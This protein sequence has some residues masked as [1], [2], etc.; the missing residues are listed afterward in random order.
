MNVH[1]LGNLKPQTTGTDAGAEI[2]RIRFFRHSAQFGNNLCTKRLGTAVIGTIHAQ[3]HH[4]SEMTRH[5]LGVVV[6]DHLRVIPQQIRDGIRFPISRNTDKRC[7]ESVTVIRPEVLQFGFKRCSGLA[8][9]LLGHNVVRVSVFVSLPNQRVE[10]FEQSVV[11]NGR[12]EKTARK[13]FKELCLI[14]LG[15]VFCGN[16]HQSEKLLRKCRSRENAEIGQ[17]HYQRVILAVRALRVIGLCKK[18]CHFQSSAMSS[19]EAKAFHSPSE[20]C[21]SLGTSCCGN[22]FVGS[23]VA[24]DNARFCSK[25]SCE[26]LCAILRVISEF[27]MVV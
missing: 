2:F 26:R 12:H 23:V 19:K 8:H 24:K 1:Q 7:R 20:D 9:E 3:V 15:C 16:N 22:F 27:V 18:S 5:V 11:V 10:R 13:L 14:A 25:R 4:L 6:F 17:G 21:S